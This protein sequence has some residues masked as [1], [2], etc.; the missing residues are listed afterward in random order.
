MAEKRTTYEETFDEGSGGWCGWR[1]H[2]INEALEIENGVATMRSPWGVDSNHAPPGAG[3]LTLLAYLYTL[4]ERGPAFSFP[5]RFVDD[6]YSR[7]LTNARMTLRMRGEAR[8]RGSQLTL[9]AQA[10]VPG[11]R[12]NFVLTGQSFQLTANWTEQTVTLAPSR[13]QW[14]CIVSRHNLGH[15]YGYG[16]IIEA[17]KDVNVDLIVVLFPLLVVPPP[18]IA[19]D[20]HRLRP[21]IDYEPDRRYLPEGEVQID[22]I[23]IEYPAT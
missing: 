2:G 5:N 10:D 1:R 20:V 15:Q 11:T 6:G 3:Y 12:A 22:T 18:E 9:L 17:L 19:D 8:L 7:D 4:P 16:D 14:T 23:R 13:S 21:E